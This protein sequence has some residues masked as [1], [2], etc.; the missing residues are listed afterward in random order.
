MNTRP[1][2]RRTRAIGCRRDGFTLVELMVSVLM[3]SV[4][5]LGL[6]GTS[7]AVARMVGKAGRQTIA[8]SV[9]ESRFEKLRSS[10]CTLL[11]GGSYTARSGIQ[12]SWVVQRVARAVIITDSVRYVDR[13]IAKSHAFQSVV[14]CPSLL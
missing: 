6:L 7:A 2:V 5:L 12:E 13:G 14:P 8:A 3:L 9:A 1:K 11:S 4:G 10:N